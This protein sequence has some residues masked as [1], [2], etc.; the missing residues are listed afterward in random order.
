MLDYRKGSKTADRTDK[1]YFAIFRS[2]VVSKNV[3][4]AD[5]I[6]FEEEK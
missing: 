5:I 1:N 4:L 6:E 2:R 3:K